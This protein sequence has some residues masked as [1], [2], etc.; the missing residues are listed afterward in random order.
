M[1]LFFQ[2]NKSL[3]SYTK[4][5]Q[6]NTFDSIFDSGEAKLFHSVTVQRNNIRD[7]STRTKDNAVTNLSLISLV[8]LKTKNLKNVNK[9][10]VFPV[11]NAQIISSYLAQQLVSSERLK[12]DAFKL[13]LLA[14]IASLTTTFLKELTIST[15]AIILGLKV[16]C[17]GK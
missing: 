10:L 3:N 12:G 15:K 17:S 4:I 7:V 16:E 8:N 9:K 1:S 14:G 11:I 5:F 13:G 6:S 2:T